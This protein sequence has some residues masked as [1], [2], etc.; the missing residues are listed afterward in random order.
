MAKLYY[1]M[2]LDVGH[3]KVDY[4]FTNGVELRHRLCPEKVSKRI[5]ILGVNDSG[6]RILWNSAWGI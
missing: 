5:G 1:A 3:Q 6:R 2:F 4:L